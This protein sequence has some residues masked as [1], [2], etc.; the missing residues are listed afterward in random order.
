V[1]LRPLDDSHNDLLH[2]LE[3]QD[4]VWE[5]VGPLLLPQ[6]GNHLFAIVEG[7]VTVG[8]GGLVRSPELRENDFELLCAMRSEV[9]LRGL[10]LRA[11]QVILAWAF[12]TAKLERVISCIDGDNEGA[13]SIAI[14]LGMKELRVIPPSRTVYVKYAH[15]E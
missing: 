8:I 2:S 3:E 13:R 10:A 7:G 6:E 5:Y 4:D 14:K 15:P 1:E 12:E 9:Q 11:C